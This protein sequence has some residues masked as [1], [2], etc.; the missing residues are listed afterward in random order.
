MKPFLQLA[1]GVLTLLVL[2]SC[3]SEEI[4]PLPTIT[5]TEEEAGVVRGS[6]SWEDG[7]RATTTNAP[8]PDILVSDQKE[9][10]VQPG[11]TIYVTFPEAPLEQKLGIWKYGSGSF[12][13][14]ID[15][16]YEAPKEPGEY[17]YGLF[18]TWDEGT[19]IFAWKIIVAE[20]R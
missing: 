12:Q 1:V 9:L 20:E 4:P 5:D 11:E 19:A 15:G 3:A 16:S 14:S 7:D 18:S 17:N 6:Y 13:T 8:S 10:V 2:I